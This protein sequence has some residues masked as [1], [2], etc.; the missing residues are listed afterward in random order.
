MKFIVMQVSETHPLPKKTF[1]NLAE[2]RALHCI[3]IYLPMDKKGSEQNRHIAQAH[4]KTCINDVRKTLVQHQMHDDEIM[5]F[6]E[7]INRLLS[8]VELW[9]N[10]SDG[11]AI[12]LNPE[13]ELL[14]FKIPISFK[15]KS[16]VANHYYLKPLLPLYHDDGFYYLLE[17][18][19]DYVK[20]FEASRYGF[21][22]VYVEDF[23]PERLEEAVGF[24]YRPTMLQFRTGQDMH[25]SGSF[26]GHGEGKDD[27]K[28]ELTSFFRAVD[29]GVK[30]AITHQNAPLVLACVDNLFNLYKQVSDHPKIHHNNVG[31]DP[32]FKKMKSLHHESWDLVA[33]YFEKT[34]K[35]KIEE[36]NELYHTQKTSYELETIIP[37]AING[38]IDTLFIS[39]GPDIYGIYDKENMELRID[40]KR[41]LA[42]TSLTNMASLRTLLHGGKVYL[43]D[44]G[45]MPIK[46]SSMNAILRY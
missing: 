9:R 39:N 28:K 12:F 36:Y 14:T 42:N 44:A 45:E 22:D 40:E 3:S 16:Y 13:E 30:K 7:P 8:K 23:A 6:L 25:G 5:T 33:Q 43:L 32:E 19:Q 46:E 34:K 21:K 35:G 2:K 41:K 29:K 27:D 26:H 38:K 17:L 10:P 4:L 24:D 20:L 1:E 31:G 18:S 37:A 11:L 15:V